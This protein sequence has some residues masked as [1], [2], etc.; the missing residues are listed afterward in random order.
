VSWDGVTVR[1]ERLSS[2][3]AFCVTI[4]QPRNMHIPVRFLESGCVCVC[5]CVRVCVVCVCVCVCLCV[6]VC[7]CVC[8]CVCVCVCVCAC[9]C[10]SVYLYVCMCVC[11]RVCARVCCV[12]RDFSKVSSTIDILHMGWLRSVGS[13]QL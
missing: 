9:V 12:V 6:C 7:V 3:E 4:E 1:R 5:V 8:G 13:L 2:A 11:V 10:L